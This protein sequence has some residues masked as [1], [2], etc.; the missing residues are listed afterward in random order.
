[1]GHQVSAMARVCATIPNL[2][3][4]EWGAFPSHEY[5]NLFPRPGYKD[6]LLELPEG[7]GVGIELNQDFIK[8]AILPGF[9]FPP[10]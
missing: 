8:E 7:P 9:E 10:A 3:A 5:D 2:F 6:G 4:L 1:M